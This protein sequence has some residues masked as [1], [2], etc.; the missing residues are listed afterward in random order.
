MGCQPK[1]KTPGMGL[2][3]EASMRP[4][5]A[6]HRLPEVVWPIGIG[7]L[8]GLLGIEPVLREITVEIPGKNLVG[9]D[10]FDRWKPDIQF[11]PPM[12]CSPVNTSGRNLGFEDRWY[13][14]RFAGKTALY[15]LELRG[16]QRR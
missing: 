7:R 14:L 12:V 15:P 8:A 10:R 2:P 3:I 13:R 1:L 11:A 6:R 9:K 5:I 16:I 4:E